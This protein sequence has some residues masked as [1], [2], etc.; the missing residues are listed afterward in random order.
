MYLIVLPYYVDRYILR[1][2]IGAGTL[3]TDRQRCATV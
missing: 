2:Y 3:L 1:W